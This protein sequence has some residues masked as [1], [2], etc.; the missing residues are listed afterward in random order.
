M[1]KI[2]LVDDDPDFVEATKLILESKSYDV[3]VAY[4]GEEGLEK[5]KEERPDAIVLDVMMPE[6]DGYKVCSQ[7]KGDPEW[8]DTPILLLTAVVS[9]IPSTRYTKEM[10]M[11]AEADDFIDKP[12]EPSELVMSIEKLLKK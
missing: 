8:R 2:L 5:V 9:H 12:V 3:V 1:Q 7:L 4:N 11:R 6:P 10:G